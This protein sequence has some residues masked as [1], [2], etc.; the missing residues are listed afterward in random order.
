[1]G[2]VKFCTQG[3]SY[4]ALIASAFPLYSAA[5]DIRVSH[6]LVS[7]PLGPRIALTAFHG[8]HYAS[9]L[10]ALVRDPRSNVL[11]IF[12]DR[13]EFT[14]IGNYTNWANGLQAIGDKETTGSLQIIS[15]AGANHFWSDEEPHRM[16]IDSARKF[17]R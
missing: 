1:M 7:Y 3:Y 17:V 8:G 9:L 15:V 16:L 12:G 13:D 11:I 10:E 2:L 14:G 6:I 4:G 5:R